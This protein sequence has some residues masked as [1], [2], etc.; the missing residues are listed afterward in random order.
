MPPF[1]NQDNST[2]KS[3][4]INVDITEES[5][6]EE[7]SKNDKNDK[8]AML[9]E[10]I[11]VA[12]K[13]I[14]SNSKTDD[15][16][17]YLQFV[18]VI[19]NYEKEE[20]SKE[21]KE[22]I[23]DATKNG[24]FIILA[25]KYNRSDILTYIMDK[26]NQTYS[27]C[28]QPRD[29][30]NENHNAFYY[31]IREEKIDFIKVL[32]EKW[33]GY[34]NSAE[35]YQA[36]ADAYAESK[37]R[38][39]ELSDKLVLY[40]AE[41][42]LDHYFYSND[43]E[44]KKITIS[45]S[46]IKERAKLLIENIRLFIAEYSNTD[47]LNSILYLRSK[48]IA[49]NINVLKQQMKAT[50]SKILWEEIEF[51]LLMFI[52]SKEQR[53]LHY[54]NLYK[55][56]ISK[57][58]LLNYL[59][60]FANILENEM[61]IISDENLDIL[62]NYPR[63]S[64][65]KMIPKILECNP[66]IREF[67]EDYQRVKDVY[68]LHIITNSVNRSLEPYS[69]LNDKHVSLDSKCGQIVIKRTLQ[70]IADMMK[71][72]WESPNMTRSLSLLLLTSLPLRTRQIIVN[73]HNSLFIHTQTSKLDKGH[74]NDPNKKTIFND[75][76]ADL[77]IIKW[78]T[79]SILHVTLIHYITVMLETITEIKT[80]EDLTNYINSL[81]IDFDTEWFGEYEVDEECNYEKLIS[82]INNLANM[83][84]G[85]E[86]STVEP[87]VNKNSL[88]GIN[89]RNRFLHTS[90]L[91]NFKNL[92][93]SIKQGNSSNNIFHKLKTYAIIAL[94]NKFDEDELNFVSPSS[95]SS[96]FLVTIECFI[97]HLIWSKC[98]HM[99]LLFNQLFLVIGH[100][101]QSYEWLEILSTQVWT[102][103]YSIALNL[104]DNMNFVREKRELSTQVLNDY[105]SKV[106]ILKKIFTNHQYGENWEIHLNLTTQLAVVMLTLELMSIL[107]ASK[108]LLDNYTLLDNSAPILT[109]KVL[110]NYIVHSGLI[111]QTFDANVAIVLNAK[112][113][114]LR[115]D[116]IKEKKIG[117]IFQNNIKELKLKHSQHLS[118]IITQN[119]MFQAIEHG[120]MKKLEDAINK[121]ADI[122]G[123]DYHGW[124]SLHYAAKGGHFAI[125]EHLIYLK[126]KNNF[127]NVNGETPLHIAV[128]YGRIEIAK[129]LIRYL[130]NP[131][132]KDYSET[133]PLY[134]AIRYGYNDIV[135]LLLPFNYQYF[136]NELLRLAMFNNRKDIVEF[137][138]K[139]TNEHVDYYR[140][141]NEETLLFTAAG[142]GY[143]ELTQYLIS[144]QAD[145][146]SRTTQRTTPLFEAAVYGF[147]NTVTILLRNKADVNA[148]NTTE[149]TALHAAVANGHEE[150]VKVLLENGAD[151]HKTDLGGY[152]PL[153]LAAKKGYLNIV[154]LLVKY[155]ADVNASTIERDTPLHLAA[156][157]G[158]FKV[159]KFLL[160]NN[161]VETALN[162]SM[163]API[164]CAAISG[165]TELMRL[166]LRRKGQISRKNLND[167][168]P[169]YLA[170]SRGNLEIVKLL[171]ERG[172]NYTELT[173]N[174][175]YNP[176]HISVRMNQLEVVKFFIR[177]KV[178]INVRT[179]M[180]STPLSIAAHNG[181]YEMV[182]LLVESGCIIN[183]GDNYHTT[184]LHLAI[185]TNHQKIVEYLINKNVDIMIQ[186]KDKRLPIHLAAECKQFNVV[187][188]LLNKNKHSI[189]YQDYRNKTPLYFACQWN[190]PELV[191]LL[192]NNG[193]KIVYNTI[194]CMDPAIMSGSKDVVEVLL[195]AGVDVHGFLPHGIPFL[196]RAVQYEQFEI[197][198]MLIAKKVD[199][200]AVSGAKQTALMIAAY[201]N[202]TGI[203]DFLLKN[204]ANPDIK[205]KNNHTALDIAIMANSY[206]TFCLLFESLKVEVTDQ[207][208]NKLNILHIAAIHDRHKMV[209]YL[210]EKGIDINGRY[211]DEYTALHTAASCNNRS[212]V[213]T[214]LEHG[215]YYD[216]ECLV[217]KKPINL[218]VDELIVFSLEI[219]DSLFSYIKEGDYIGCLDCLKRN[220]FVNAKSSSSLTP[221]HYACQ[222]GFSDIVK[223]LLE[224]NADINMTAH[225]GT[226]LVYAVLYKHYDVVKILLKY[227][228]VY[229]VI[230][231]FGGNSL[232]KLPVDLDISYLLELIDI[233]F[234]AIIKCD[235]TIVDEI[236]KIKDLDILQCIL[237]A[238]NTDNKQL[239]LEAQN[240]KFPEDKFAE[241]Y[242]HEA[243][244][245]VKKYT[246]NKLL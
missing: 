203:A 83:S 208:S 12:T 44:D 60:L 174:S 144:I 9:S 91:K 210:I 145:V 46:D 18:I 164:H 71:N 45:L 4:S 235:I 114:C 128:R 50:Y 184:P 104:D 233:A 186:L 15:F 216:S 225:L 122:N 217:D 239:Y 106:K 187:A 121:G 14:I 2:D 201:C 105:N 199:V 61:K 97:P 159:A 229:N 232:V 158:H 195:N 84:I 228:A 78:M 75:I 98:E 69:N 111:F 202:F 27:S 167:H 166:L 64:R 161:A 5:V 6:L 172:A 95:V 76:K 240:S 137:L 13:N 215:A 29:Q 55:F 245:C 43:E 52:T 24:N 175:G 88:N 211:L 126:V 103:R 173:K 30:D 109:G 243:Y 82:E 171:V 236:K 108:N 194:H 223:L 222:N 163:N 237:N 19:L 28:C 80:P 154:K 59:D 192:I 238:R 74:S 168:D 79:Q 49:F 87:L 33:P 193:A 129:W 17:K 73:F 77:K 196:H 35:L 190:H 42:L 151:V 115:S 36:F 146:N 142:C 21:F 234:D 212:T 56:L 246:L 177:K 134:L 67:Y 32:L 180:C 153:H 191:K 22:T 100:G 25:C 152:T 118:C 89:A 132:I 94:K 160:S 244:L 101:L 209:R 107:D 227:G 53:K 188:T 155:K 81:D 70:V 123:S 156:G 86:I 165:D 189:H 178:D 140:T 230:T 90:N 133:T 41:R 85:L 110:Y 181:L 63:E 169:L 139:N 183:I 176:L 213:K 7:Y 221:L 143:S 138:L 136:Y 38:G 8:T 16:K 34:A 170:A 162:D 242:A 226:P 117:K 92:C 197:V 182:K 37:V 125:F 149:T 218:A 231:K 10:I 214:S 93:K 96:I 23:Q 130:Q 31:A 3:A 26:K 72:N 66:K 40:I 68:A 99:M 157:G 116:K 219:I 131:E 54:M 39:L 1:Q 205:D 206:E 179:A 112:K 48:F 124:S 135:K 198:K 58:K 204:K 148:S 127:K 200:N 113:L 57:S 147:V 11:S 207:T 150:V 224:F 51:Y 47:D 65:V 220:A 141:Y 241:M 120:D 62:K 102:K 20:N 185:T 119:E